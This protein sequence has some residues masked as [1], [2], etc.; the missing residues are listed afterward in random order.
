[1]RSHETSAST[2]D[3]TEVVK[4]KVATE[5]EQRKAELQEKIRAKVPVGKF[6]SVPKA[7]QHQAEIDAYK[8]FPNGVNPKTGEVGGPLRPE[9]TR[10]GDW[11]CKGRD[12]DF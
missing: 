5:K 1:M 12:T 8:P 6:D 10:Y 3:E 2:A 9:P 11:E 7:E 4:L